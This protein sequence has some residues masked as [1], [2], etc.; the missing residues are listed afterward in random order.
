MDLVML[1]LFIFGSVGCT[2][3]IVDGSIFKWL[4]EGP[5]WIKI[6]LKTNFKI[7]SE[8]NLLFWV[9]DK[10]TELLKCYVCSGF[11]CGFIVSS[12]TLPNITWSQAFLLGGGA[13]SILSNTVAIYLNYLEAQTFI[14]L[15]KQDEEE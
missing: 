14:S 10:L 11:W 2:H 8:K 12:L 3:I 5:E 7:S 9:L 15:P 13:S 1:V 6:N 4:R